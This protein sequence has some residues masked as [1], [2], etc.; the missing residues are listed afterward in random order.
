MRKNIL[1]LVLLFI[2][3][4]GATVCDKAPTAPDHSNPLDPKHGPPKILSVAPRPA[5]ADL[6]VDTAIVVRFDDVMDAKTITETTFKVQHTLDNQTL[7]IKGKLSFGQNANTIA[8]FA[9]FAPEGFYLYNNSIAVS[10]IA[11]NI[12]DTEGLSL[13]A[14]NNN[15]NF[16]TYPLTQV[17]QLK[18]FAG[19]QVFRHNQIFIISANSTAAL[20]LYGYKSAADSLD[21]TS[22]VTWKPAAAYL[23][24][25]SGKTALLNVGNKNELSAITACIYNKNVS[26][27]AD[28]VSLTLQI[29]TRGPAAP[30]L[31]APDDGKNMKIKPTFQWNSVTGAVRYLIVVDD[32]NTFSP[33]N[34]IPETEVTGL[35]F[36][37]PFDLADKTYYW[38]VLAINNLGNRGAWSSPTRSFIIDTIKPDKPPTLISPDPGKSLND[39]TPTFTWFAV[40]DASFYQVQVANNTTFNSSSIVDTSAYSTTT[41]Y[42]ARRLSPDGT[43]YWRVF[44]KDLAG[45]VSD[46]SQTRSIIIDTKVPAKPTVISPLNEHLSNLNPPLEFKWNQV[47]ETDSYE[48]QLDNNQNFS[49]PEFQQELTSS[50]AVVSFVLQN[51]Q[52]PD[53]RYYWHVRAKDVA[54][55]ASAWSDS[56]TTAR[57]VIIDRL[58][59]SIPTLKTPAAGA[60]V[61]DK[62]P[63]FDWDDVTDTPVPFPVV[64]RIQIYDNQAAVNPIIDQP[65]LRRSEFTVPDPDSLDEGNYYWQVLAKDSVGNVSNWSEFRSVTIYFPP[66][67][68]PALIKP[69]SLIGGTITDTTPEFDWESVVG[70]ETYELQVADSADVDGNPVASK[71]VI[72]ET[73]LSNSFFI[74]PNDK[75]L[76]VDK[77]YFW[78]VRAK[79]KNNNADSLSDWSEVWRFTIPPNSGGQSSRR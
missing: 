34:V 44:A 36:P 72:N 5:A 39:P 30:V 15:W 65:G 21:I 66:P 20:K 23:S 14:E 78:R 59:P 50:N 73:A 48:I 41:S 47:A 58:F 26:G 11:A 60:Q 31:V 18:L 45:N 13:T 2:V 33:P 43:Y 40:T 12:K 17:T 4:L 75:A 74:V 28:S 46:P 69:G 16:S 67:E 10:L 27:K 55:N 3:W 1:L 70:A 9:R 52:R 7:A 37:A 63:R 42:E 62:T 71:L 38:R 51:F 61:P 19:G 77:T 54:G 68:A 24:V 76:V 6:P 35:S 64:Y 53:G 56:G 49:S 79:D 8:N 25:Q 32:E 22:T 57:S 29:D